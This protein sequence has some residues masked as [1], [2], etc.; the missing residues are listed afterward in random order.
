[1]LQNLAHCTWIWRAARDIWQW[2]AIKGR[3]EQP[4]SWPLALSGG[5]FISQGGTRTIEV[6]SYGFSMQ[7]NT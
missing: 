2:F 4:G 3:P 7:E 1:M 5:A 6:I